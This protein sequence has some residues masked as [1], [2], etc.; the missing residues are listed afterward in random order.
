MFHDGDFLMC[1]D[2]I[3][4]NYELRIK[5]YDFLTF[6]KWKKTAANGIHD[7]SEKMKKNTQSMDGKICRL[8][9]GIS[10]CT[11]FDAGNINI[12]CKIIA[13]AKTEQTVFYKKSYMSKSYI[14]LKL[15]NCYFSYCF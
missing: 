13:N 1:K 3:Y 10:Y 12:G 5:N 6:G 9:I 7:G 11:R 2:T 14:V 15:I 8:M 4:F